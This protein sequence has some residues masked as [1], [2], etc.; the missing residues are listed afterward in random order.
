MVLTNLSE[1]VLSKEIFVK[2]QVALSQNPCPQL[3]HP[4]D[5]DG[6]FH[7]N[8]RQGA[9]CANGRRIVIVWSAMKVTV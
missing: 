8:E 9:K 5:K 1:N 2:Y 6:G 3:P 7:L 4:K